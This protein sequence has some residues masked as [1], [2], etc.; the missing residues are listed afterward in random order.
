MATCSNCQGSGYKTCGA[1]HGTGKTQGGPPG[2]EKRCPVC[3]NGYVKCRACRGR[4]TR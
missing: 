2:H 1:C 4:G 3:I